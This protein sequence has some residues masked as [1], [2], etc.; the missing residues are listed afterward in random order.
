MAVL[1]SRVPITLTLFILVLQ[2]SRTITG[3]SVDRQSCGYEISN[4][5]ISAS[6]NEVDRIGHA[7]SE[8]IDQL[9]G[10]YRKRADVDEDNKRR[11]L[12]PLQLLFG[13]DIAEPSAQQRLRKI[14]RM[15]W[16]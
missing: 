10:Y 9:W 7:G 3:L 15:Y 8:A 1:S 4:V 2:F 16:R 5:I 13:Q 12:M 14:K 6:L 11:I